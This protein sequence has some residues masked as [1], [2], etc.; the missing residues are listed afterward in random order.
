[1]TALPRIGKQHRRHRYWPLLAIG[2]VWLLATHATALEINGEWRQ[3]E[4][5]TGQV[6]PGSAVEIEGRKARVGDDGLFVF[7]LDRDAPQQVTVTVT[8]PS[9]A[10][11][12][13]Q[14]DVAQREYNIQRIDNPPPEELARIR[15]ESALTREARTASLERRDFLVDFQ[16][17]VTGPI[18]GVYGSQRY[19]NGEPRRPHYGVDIAAPTGTTVMAPAG[20][21]VTMA[22]DNMFFSGGT[23]IIDHGYG[24]SSSF[25]H[26]SKIL[27]EEG[28]EVEQG[29]PVAEVGATGR[30]TG[31]HLDW[32]INWFTRRLDPQPL[33]GPMPDSQ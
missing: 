12:S 5:L 22:H 9:G 16:W 31:A 8:D 17:P 11:E 26:L 2:W 19:Y 29:Q 1:V 4:M 6:E 13:H 3:G 21:V 10:T 27:V 18:T 20:G 28:E 14:F 33:V 23:L 7:G 32:R 24:I 25:L 30:V 15:R